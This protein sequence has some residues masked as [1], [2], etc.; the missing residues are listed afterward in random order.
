MLLHGI[1]AVSA[2]VGVKWQGHVNNTDHVRLHEEMR[3]VVACNGECAIEC[4]Y[5]ESIEIE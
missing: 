5:K 3:I 1:A 2:A 4:E